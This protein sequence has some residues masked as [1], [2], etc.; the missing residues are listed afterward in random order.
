MSRPPPSL[1]VDG[2]LNPF[3]ARPQCRPEGCATI[4]A[5][6]RPGRPLRVWLKTPPPGLVTR[7]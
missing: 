2:P 6:V 5:S 3:A 4:R 7:P 1:H